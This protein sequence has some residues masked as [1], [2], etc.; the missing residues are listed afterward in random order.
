MP[1]AIEPQVVVGCARLDGRRD[2]A[3]PVHHGRHE[4]ILQ[5]A[6]V[7][8][9]E[10]AVVLEG[11]KPSLDAALPVLDVGVLAVERRDVGQPRDDQVEVGVGVHRIAVYRLRHRGYS[12]D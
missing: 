7:G 4:I 2:Q 1:G 8:R 12:T 5:C 11:L 3:V 6:P 9:K 10:A